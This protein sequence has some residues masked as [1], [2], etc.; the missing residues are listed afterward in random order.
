MNLTEEEQCSIVANILES[1]VSHL[2]NMLS[3]YSAFG[4]WITKETK[5]VLIKIVK[6]VLNHVDTFTFI[7]EHQFRL[8]EM[9]EC[10]LFVQNE[11]YINDPVLMKLYY[12]YESQSP[13]LCQILPSNLRL[14][15]FRHCF[16]DCHALRFILSHKRFNVVYIGGL[17]NENDC[18][19][20]RIIAPALQ[21][22]MPSNCLQLD[23]EHI[24]DEG[25][26]IVAKIIDGAITT[27]LDVHFPEI[28]EYGF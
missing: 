14:M 11:S 25:A 13:E 26:R 21:G 2:T 7:N 12:I 8:R 5:K 10:S 4:G 3:F 18:Y 1:D 16:R 9:K 22:N 19:F 23:A 6:N 28:T 15:Y 20:L 24:G 27:G 17:P